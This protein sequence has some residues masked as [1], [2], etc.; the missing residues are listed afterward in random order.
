MSDVIM[1]TEIALLNQEVSSLHRLVDN[2]HSKVDMLVAMQL[3]LQ[4]LQDR[5]DRQEADFREHEEA[6]RAVT[7]RL[8]RDIEA[9][10]KATDGVKMQVNRWVNMGIGG[11]F[12]GG[13]LIGALQ[14]FVLREIAS[15]RAAGVTYVDQQVRLERLECALL[16]DC[17]RGD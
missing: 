1:Q 4:R 12:V 17:S 9:C 15:Y 5:T 3:N 2:V 11:V 6:H 13:I 14:W 7:D 16:K 8:G 10:F